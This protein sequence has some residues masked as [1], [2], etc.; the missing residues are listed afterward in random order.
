[1]LLFYLLLVRSKFMR[2]CQNV[3]HVEITG[4]QETFA[5]SF[6]VLR[7]FLWKDFKTQ[8]MTMFEYKKKQIPRF[9]ITVYISHCQQW[10]H[11]NYHFS[12]TAVHINTNSGCTEVK[13]RPLTLK[14]TI[15]IKTITCNKTNT[16]VKD[17]SLIEQLVLP[18]PTGR[19]EPLHYP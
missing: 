6:V 7:L 19:A 11:W 8:T 16:S 5:T 12:G 17:L 13:Q 1:M 14:L 10:H 3:I 18:L 2:I 15:Q 9:L 4:K